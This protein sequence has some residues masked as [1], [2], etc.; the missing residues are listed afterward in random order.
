VATGSV[1]L[2]DAFSFCSVPSLA[3]V[4]IRMIVER[5]TCSAA[6]TSAIVT[7]SRTSRR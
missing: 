3:T 5:S 7:T 1:A 4:R 2:T 6:A